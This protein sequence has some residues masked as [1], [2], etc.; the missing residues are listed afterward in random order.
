MLEIDSSLNMGNGLSTK[1]QKEKTPP[2][3]NGTSNI[4][5]GICKQNTNIVDLSPNKCKYDSDYSP[6]V[7]LKHEHQ[8]G[9]STENDTSEVNSI[10]EE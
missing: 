6:L 3:S 8:K 9:H 5:N 1:P 7:K 2:L 10:S 4:P